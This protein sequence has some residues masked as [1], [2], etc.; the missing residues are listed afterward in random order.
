MNVRLILGEGGVDVI[1]SVLA[2]VCAVV[3]D[4][5]E[6]AELQ[7]EQVVQQLAKGVHSCLVFPP[8]LQT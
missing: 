5:R 1:K 6:G 8:P 2:E 3:G 4:L 7:G